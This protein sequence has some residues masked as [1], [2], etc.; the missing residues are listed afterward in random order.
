MT[1]AAF[2]SSSAASPVRARF[3]LSPPLAQGAVA[4][5]LAAGA[6]G[7]LLATD[8]DT[9]AHAIANAGADLTRLLRAMAIIKAGMGLAVAAGVLWRLKTP[10]SA[11]WLAAYVAASAAM[12]AG[13]G[14]IWDMSHLKLGALLL[15]AGLITGMI[16]LWRD[17]AVSRRLNAA[18]AARRAAPGG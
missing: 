15:H 10:A 17:P 8:G 3:T 7:G 18:I 4:L 14:L 6:A 13:P 5:A 2:Q 16:L 12:A 11:P 1:L 9:A